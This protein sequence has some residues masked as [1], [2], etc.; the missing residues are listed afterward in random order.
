MSD[1]I[2]AVRIGLMLTLALGFMGILNNNV[3]E[4]VELGEI[5]TIVLS[6]FVLIAMITM[7]I[8]K[9]NLNTGYILLLIGSVN[10]GAFVGAIVWVLVS[11]IIA[12][13]YKDMSLPL[14]SNLLMVMMIVIVRKF[15]IDNK[16]KTYPVQGV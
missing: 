12:M 4:V 15:T 13:P 6:L 7:V 10:L 16:I 1:M 8:L 2:K 14:V 5:I 3:L 11:K 9:T